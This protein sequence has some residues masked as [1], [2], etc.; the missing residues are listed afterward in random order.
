VTPATITAGSRIEDLLRAANGI[1]AA[2]D[3]ILSQNFGKTPSAN[4]NKIEALST[5]W[6]DYAGGAR[7]GFIAEIA[8]LIEKEV[9][10]NLVSLA[11]NHIL[12]GDTLAA[13]V[14]TAPTD[15]GVGPMSMG[16]LF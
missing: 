4:P 1:G 2:L 8:G 9:R 6:V 10:G 14:S 12:S 16:S 5:L 13:P 7:P 3:Y 11:T 15:S